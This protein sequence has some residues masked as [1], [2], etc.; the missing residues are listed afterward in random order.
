MKINTKKGKFPWKK[1]K[2][3]PKLG[4]LTQKRKNF[5]FEKGKLTRKK[6]N[7]V[8]KSGN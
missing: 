1:W 4:N 3:T 2:L 8:G 7:S 6:E 5:P